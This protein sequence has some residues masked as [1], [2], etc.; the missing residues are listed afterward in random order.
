MPFHSSSHLVGHFPTSRYLHQS[1]SD[2]IFHPFASNP[3]SSHHY[4]PHPPT[5]GLH[6]THLYPIPTKAPCSFSTI[7]TSLKPSSAP[8]KLRNHGVPPLL[9]TSL[10]L[11]A[12]ATP[13]RT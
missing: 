10:L 3:H 7:S 11:T 6:V 9:S 8:Q 12:M 2:F 4:P 13:S 5:H 1:F